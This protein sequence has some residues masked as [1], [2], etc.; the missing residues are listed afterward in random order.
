MLYSKNE[1]KEYEELSKKYN[2]PKSVIELICHYPFKFAAKKLADPI[3]TKTIMLSYLFK[4]KI[5]NRFKDNKHLKYKQGN[6]L[7]DE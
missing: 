2:I 6:I 4:I 3:D 7:I 5:K 1:Q